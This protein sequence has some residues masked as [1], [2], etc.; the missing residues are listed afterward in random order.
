M[1]NVSGK[2]TACSDFNGS[3]ETEK[4]IC[5][6]QTSKAWGLRLGDFIL[7]EVY[8]KCCDIQRRCFFQRDSPPDNRRAAHSLFLKTTM[9]NLKTL[10]TYNC[11]TKNNITEESPENRAITLSN[12]PATAFTTIQ[13]SISAAVLES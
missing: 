1:G 12:L 3:W 11:Q 2:W 10:K 5:K 8:F 6:V 7:V 4:S 9:Q 13:N